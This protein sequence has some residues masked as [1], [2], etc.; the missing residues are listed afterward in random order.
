MIWFS[1][2]AVSLGGVNIWKKPFTDPA[3]VK[4]ATILK[5]IISNYSTSDAIGLGAGGSG[6]HFLAARTAVFA[7]GPWW[8]GRKDLSETPFFNSIKIAGIPAAGSTDNFVISR[9]QANICAAATKDPNRK[10]AILDF[11]KYLTKPEN[12]KRISESSGA[13]F[14]IK[15]DYVPDNP[16]QKQFYKLADSASKSAFDLE[17][18][19]G[20][21]VTM[22][23]E[24]QLGALVLGDI[25]PEQFC[26]LV[27]A[28][29]DR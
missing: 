12:I 20:S 5:R 15:T 29:I 27:D 4:A 14:A 10:A 13:M 22:E 26:T 28:K 1:H 16:L 11:L 25:T 9:L 21:E 17:A 8:T 23:F 6:G 2:L 18:A 24:Q 19:L 7:N 3:F